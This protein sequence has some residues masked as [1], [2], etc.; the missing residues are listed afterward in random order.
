[1]VKT[2][3]DFKAFGEIIAK[4]KNVY[5][6]GLWAFDCEVQQLIL[7]LAFG[8]RALLAITTKNKICYLETN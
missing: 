7:D 1:M 6:N 4:N 8:K 5:I 3:K 2:M